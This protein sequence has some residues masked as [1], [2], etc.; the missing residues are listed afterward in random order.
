MKALLYTVAKDVNSNL[1]DA[2]NAEKGRLFFCPLCNTA[3][4]L[5]KSGKIGKG[6]KRPH[7]A[8]RTLTPNC[9]P[10]TALH[11]LFKHLLAA[12]FERH[13]EKQ[14][15][16]EFAWKCTYC[17]ERHSG[18][19]MKKTRS[20]KVEYDLTVCRP[21]IALLDCEGRVFAVVEIVVTHKPEES[22]VKFYEENRIS[23]IQIELTSDEDIDNL[24]NKIA[25]PDRVGLCYNPRCEKCGQHKQRTKMTI[26][27]C[28][29]WSCGSP[30]KVAIVHG[31][32]LRWG[33]HIG[34]DRF[35]KGEIEFAKRQGVI[36]NSKYSETVKQ[37]YMANSCPKCPAFVG[38][39]YLF[40]SYFA[41]AGCGELQ[42]T[43]LE[44]GYHCGHYKP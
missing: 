28:T 36:L 17:F 9:T 15:P 41:P 8:H 39:H 32:Q 11:H 22:V 6:T 26:V 1:V 30:M 42:S 10:E 19:L 4:T 14:T 38:N 29:C 2:K 44:I 43:E 25:N 13:L 35:T 21:D 31:N 18:N 23:L 20:V 37:R 33:S 16:L 7:F 3:L 34:P 27:E 12:K 40:T 24:D 5:R